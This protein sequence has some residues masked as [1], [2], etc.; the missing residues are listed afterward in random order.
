MHW[1]HDVFGMVMGG[2]ISYLFYSAVA[3]AQRSVP[4]LRECGE[5]T[6][7]ELPPN[8]AWLG[9]MILGV[10]LLGP[11]AVVWWGVLLSRAKHIFSLD[12]GTQ[13]FAV[14]LGMFSVVMTATFIFAALR[15]W[16]SRVLIFSDG[17]LL[18]LW[19]K[20]SAFVTWESI[21]K[22]E[23]RK[24]SKEMRIRTTD[25]SRYCLDSTWNG[26]GFLYLCFVHFLKEE[27]WR[28]AKD[29]I[30]EFLAKT[31]ELEAVQNSFADTLLNG[32]VV[33]AAE[34]DPAFL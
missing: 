24:H 8:R 33:S 12:I 22:V 20:K 34:I 7:L 18:S 2:T 31:K 23:Y 4:K 9:M 5:G 27:Q 14:F 15:L 16:K 29:A 13:V 1:I 28:D 25:S 6:V 3:R 10:F 26:V 30:D 19:P 32:S 11:C 21:A 17:L